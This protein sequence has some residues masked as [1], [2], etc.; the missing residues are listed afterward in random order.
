MDY[1]TI[2]GAL[3]ARQEDDM[4]KYRAYLQKHPRK[5]KSRKV[6]VFYGSLATQLE[7]WMKS[8]NGHMPF[9]P[10][11]AFYTSKCFPEPLKFWDF[12][13]A[14]RRKRGL[15]DNHERGCKAER[16][17]D[18]RDRDSIVVCRVCG[19]ELGQF[20]PTEDVDPVYKATMESDDCLDPI[21]LDAIEMFEGVTL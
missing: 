7:E 16:G 15:W 5:G 8:P 9:S 2:H 19:A 13:K 6:P 10:K 1:S 11:Q 12:W 3:Q 18:I 21:D 14:E 17:L 20:V 4:H